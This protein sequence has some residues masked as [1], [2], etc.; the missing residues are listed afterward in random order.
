MSHMTMT[1][2]QVRLQFEAQFKELM[3][4]ELDGALPEAIDS[5]IYM[6]MLLLRTLLERRLQL[7]QPAEAIEDLSVAVYASAT[8]EPF[9]WAY[10]QDPNLLAGHGNDMLEAIEQL[11]HNIQE[12]I[13]AS[14][15][16][17]LRI[18]GD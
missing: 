5:S 10:P 16:L 14:H 4:H 15:E 13:S 9:F 6:S 12:G 3:L 17:M 8:S 1:A 2:E 7:L 18:S 11:R